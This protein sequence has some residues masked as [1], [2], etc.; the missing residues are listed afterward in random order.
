MRAS[1]TDSLSIVLAFWLS[2]EIEAFDTDSCAC[3]RDLWRLRRSL[4]ENDFPH[5]HVK[6]F[7]C[8]S[9]VFAMN[10]WTQTRG[11]HV[12]LTSTDVSLEMLETSE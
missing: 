7:S 1:D 4:R 11:N 10:R 5:V 9:C 8:V 12:I 2:G 3:A 6:G